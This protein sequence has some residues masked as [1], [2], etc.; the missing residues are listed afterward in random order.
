MI[1]A[2]P[3]GIRRRTLAGTDRNGDPIET[4]SDPEP[5]VAFSIGPRYAYEV[6]AGDTAITGLILG[7]PHSYGLRPHDRVVIDDDEWAVDG[8]LVNANRGPFGYRPGWVANL[9]RTED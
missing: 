8:E 3:F 6:G 1:A 2:H 9:R 4:W 5:A 7:L